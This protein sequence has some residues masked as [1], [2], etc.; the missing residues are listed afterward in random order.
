[1]RSI[2]MVF[3]LFVL[4]A[5][6]VPA[7]AAK[8]QCSA[9]QCSTPT[10]VADAR[11]VVA[12]ACPCA[13]ATSRKSYAKCWKPLVRAAG[14]ARNCRQSMSRGLLN[15]T[16]GQLGTVLCRQV[17]KKGK[18][19]CSVK[20]AAKCAQPFESN[21]F[22]NCADTC[23]EIVALPFPSTRELSATDLN[24]L[25]PD[26]GDG[27]LRFDPAP[28]ALANVAVGSILVA[29]VSANTPSGL[30][31]AVL[32]V[33]RDGNT[34]T[35]RTGQAPIQLAYRKLHSRV[36]RSMSVPAARGVGRATVDEMRPFNYT[37]FDGDGDGETTNDQ[38]VIEG[39]IGGGFDF[40]F[41]L[42]VDWGDVTALPDVVK[43]CLASFAD[44]LVGDPPRCS[45][46]DLLPEAKVTFVVFPRVAANT[47]VHGAAIY[48]YEKEVDLAS[49]T[50]A[51]IIVGPLIFVPTADV[52][53]QLSGGASGAFS[54][55]LHGSAVFET[56]VTVSSKQ[57]QTPQF[58]QPVLKSTDF[59]PNDTSVTLN[60]EAK[61]GVGARL[62][63]LLFGVTGPYAT[64]RAYGALAA[65]IFQGP[66]FSL[67]AGLEADLGIKVTS[68]ALPLLG[69]V[70]LVD[71]KAPTVN[72]LDIELLT[73]QCAPP[74]NVSTLPPGSGA[75]A[76]RYAMPTYTPWS[77]T[78]SSPVE[79][80][81]AITPGNRAAFS[82]LQRT[83]DNRYVRSGFG[84]HTLTKFDD[85]GG[86]VWAR[87]LQFDGTP[88]F[89]LRVRSARDAGLVV[90]SRAITAP[91]VLTELAQDG[92]VVEA[93]GYDIPLDI[94]NVD[95]TALAADGGSG[96]Y[97]TGRCADDTR[98]FLLHAQGQ[99]ATFRLLDLP[100]SR[101][102]VVESIAGDAFLAGQVREAGDALVA[103][104]LTPAGGVVYSKR[105]DGCV[106]AS[107][108][109]PSTAL[110]GP[111]GE[112]TIAGSGGAEHNGIV[113]RLR[114]DGAV[115]FTAFP[116]FGLGAG[117]VFILDSLVELPT[118]GYV[119]GGSFVKLT[120]Q[121]PENVPSAA[122]V[123]LDAGGHIL[124]ANRYT[125][126]GPGSYE[127]SGD[128]AIRLSDDGGTVA[129]AI[130]ADASDPL[131][132]RLWAFKPFAKDGSITFQ[133]GTA[134]VEP[135]DIVD[136]ACSFTARDQAVGIEQRAIGTRRVV[137][138]STAVNLGVA[139]QTAQ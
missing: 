27:T 100:N 23:D 54:T 108:A 111:T 69:H 65:D 67:H 124:W 116:G 87:D 90:V 59:G 33:E 61:V 130:V 16:C 50:L 47:N 44:V 112:V 3:A 95:V 78:F 60:A 19:T 14:L 38:V 7:A 131:G 138:T 123:G 15:S 109:I 127:S 110:V 75:D 29:G 64:A 91:I 94:C 84:V 83:I 11:A 114:R 137:V 121:V 117:D 101:L 43:D 37:L 120:G 5:A 9:T 1:M 103:L 85:Q 70:T 107:D 104:R 136:L 26:P 48:Q 113:L 93:F 22:A 118:T 77:R 99:T 97:V 128:V 86:L 115:G 18:Q 41:A 57:T 8:F 45:I 52:T 98:S 102:N 32:A 132:G 30:L 139:Q 49:E 129:T 62:N 122:L 40:D 10:L 80:S 88:L 134:S 126:G 53:A 79:G 28:A 81:V 2:V 25:N 68:P 133:P 51:P 20:K 24:A 6:A 39:V 82:E 17:T 72:P 92:S 89:P 12:A 73:G 76:T 63:V 106:Q 105:Y 21:V 31:R 35:L 46:D 96:W 71:W 135:L 74:P 13:A 58:K 66:C 125:F 36:V 56:S 4:V 34:L 119:A 42:D 55:G